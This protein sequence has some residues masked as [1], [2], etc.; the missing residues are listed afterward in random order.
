MVFNSQ[1]FV[2]TKLPCKCL[3]H[4]IN[5]H[6]CV[7]CQKWRDEYLSWFP[8]QHG[9]LTTI[10]LPQDTIWTLDLMLYNTLVTKATVSALKLLVSYLSNCMLIYVN[11]CIMANNL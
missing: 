8:W 6:I 4:I 5:K 11:L 10:K 7:F 9:N 2:C 1:Q 3:T